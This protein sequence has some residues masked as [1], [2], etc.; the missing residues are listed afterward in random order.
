[1]T[2]ALR[3]SL[4]LPFLSTVLNVFPKYNHSSDFHSHQAFAFPFF[5]TLFLIIFSLSMHSYGIG[6]FPFLFVYSSSSKKG[7]PREECREGPLFGEGMGGEA[8]RE[9]TSK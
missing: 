9:V 2:P 3:S 6:R 1:M 4:H 8:G 7:S 5:P